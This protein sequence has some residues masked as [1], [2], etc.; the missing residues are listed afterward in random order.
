M[1]ARGPSWY[2]FTIAR[3]RAWVLTD[4]PVGRVLPTEEFP[5]AAGQEMREVLGR[6]HLPT[7]YLD[8]EQNCLVV[9]AE[10]GLILFDAGMGSSKLFGPDTGRLPQSFKDAG[11]DPQDV[12]AVFIT[13]GHPDHL[14]GVTD[15]EGNRC[16]PRAEIMISRED[17]E[18]WTSDET[19]SRSEFLA[20]NVAGARER[21]RAY[22]ER[23]RFIGEGEE[24]V[25][26]V[27]AVST[28]GHTVGHLSFMLGAG[29]ERCFV[30]GDCGYHFAVSLV[31]PDWHSSF[32][33]DPEL[34]V[35][36]RKRTLCGVADESIRVLGYH[37]P[38]PGIGYIDRVGRSAF[39][40]TPQPMDLR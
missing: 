7:E 25:A 27:R 8:M 33:T 39:R 23:I 32:D 15:A 14:F 28:S 6:H 2:Q 18:F 29:E 24:P 31:R 16:F 3:R 37:F 21:L 20:Q 1:G 19:A 11:L 30:L 34:A 12:S 17:F 5:G 36:T 26:G 10:K 22:S 35:A 38:F 4:G 9:E 40:F 13:H